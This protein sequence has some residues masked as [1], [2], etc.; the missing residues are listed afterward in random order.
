[1]TNKQQL[2]D[3]ILSLEPELK[4]KEKELTKMLETIIKTKPNVKISESFRNDLRSQ[5]LY[6]RANSIFKEK[7]VSYV[8]I[9]S[10]FL[11]WWVTAFSIAWIIWVNFEL[12]KDSEPKATS[13]M[14]W[15]PTNEEIWFK[16]AMNLEATS[17]MMADDSEVM[18]DESFEMAESMIP[19]AIMEEEIMSISSFESFDENTE[20][21]LESELLQFL[22][23]N[24]LDIKHLETLLNIISKYIK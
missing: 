22:K 12:F 1:M 15:V 8:Q 9:I 24:N 18:E 6:S 2:I 23:D 10:W 14:R 17:M 5:L 20:V 7:K 21:N 4:S 3:E 19:E 13:Y 16:R 11:V